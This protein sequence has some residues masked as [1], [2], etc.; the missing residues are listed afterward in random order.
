[1]NVKFETYQERTSGGKQPSKDMLQGQSGCY[2]IFH[3][4]G[5]YIGSSRNLAQRIVSNL[6]H[7]R[8]GKHKNRNLQAAYNDDKEVFVLYAVT[9][10]EQEAQELEQVMVDHY[11]KG[12]KLFNIATDNV[13][14]TR[15]GVPM[16][17]EH[18]E[19]LRQSNVTRIVTDETRA[20]LREKRLGKTLPESVKRNL[21]AA[22]KRFNES[23][24][25]K[26]RK[27]AAVAKLSYRCKI[28]GIEYASIMDAARTLGIKHQVINHRLR[29]RTER[30]ADYILIEDK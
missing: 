1:M 4:K 25:G 14:L 10:T 28:H 18:L 2:Q 26:A 30:F 13:L 21:S 24:E 19:A 29:S 22:L 20:K 23:D 5:V 16:T 7:L 27:A 11:K 12:D 3:A 17:A 6:W 9:A 15:I 8:Q